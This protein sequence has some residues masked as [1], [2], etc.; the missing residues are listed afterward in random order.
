MFSFFSTTPNPL[1][2]LLFGFSSSG[3]S[4]AAA[5]EAWQ[6]VAALGL[7]LEVGFWARDIFFIFCFWLRAVGLFCGV[8]FG[9][10]GSLGLAMGLPLCFWGMWCNYVGDS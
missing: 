3:L 4:C 5:E 8:R 2:D 10:L 1:P 7:G 6:V 9:V